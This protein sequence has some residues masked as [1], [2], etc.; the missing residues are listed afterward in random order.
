MSPDMQGD[1]PV[2][3]DTSLLNYLR[4]IGHSSVKEGCGEGDCGACT[5]VIAELRDGVL[6]YKAINS[7]LVLLPMVHACQVITAESLSIKKEGKL[8]LHPV[9]QA[10]VDHHGSQCG[11]CTP[12]IVMS[13]FALWKEHTS[14]TTEMLK[15][16]LAGNLCRCTGYQ[17]IIEAFMALNGLPRKDHFADSSA[18]IIKGL[19]TIKEKSGDIMIQSA[20]ME[21]YK[22]GNLKASLQLRSEH[23]DATIIGGATDVAVAVNKRKHKLKKVLDISSL[24][25]LKSINRDDSNICLGSGI[26]IEELGEAIKDEFTA[27]HDII[28]LF[29][30]H[31]IRNLP[32]LSN[33]KK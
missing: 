29:G 4:H 8:Y 15:H 9:Q 16:R 26:S 10:M 19:R 21:Y 25:E 3:A 28:M 31:Q 1:G 30:S 20:G 22:P 7:C 33:R 27:L 23:P 11:Y 2:R 12:G 24:E 32:C 18:K 6:H 14:V 17:P 5:V 13:L